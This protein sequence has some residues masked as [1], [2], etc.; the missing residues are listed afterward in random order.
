MIF[1]LIR[2]YRWRHAFF[3]EIGS[4]GTLALSALVWLLVAIATP[5]PIVVKAA[6]K[7]P[8]KDAVIDAA[9][10]GARTIHDRLPENIRERIPEELRSRISGEN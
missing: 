4:L 3:Y 2:H 1:V 10:S 7:G 5:A 6:V 8:M 9:L